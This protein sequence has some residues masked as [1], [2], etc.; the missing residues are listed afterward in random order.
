MITTCW[1]EKREQRWDVRA[2]YDLLSVSSVQEIAGSEGGDQCASQMTAC[3]E[4]FV[5]IDPRTPTRNTM[6]EPRS[7]RQPV[8]D[9]SPSNRQNTMVRQAAK[10]KGRKNLGPQTAPVPS[11]ATRKK[12]FQ[13]SIL[14][15]SGRDSESRTDRASQGKR[16]GRIAVLSWGRSKLQAMAKVLTKIVGLGKSA[17]SDE[18]PSQ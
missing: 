9:R 12:R 7:S 5:D 1:S 10:E 6:I 14:S 11:T 4:G 8:I 15:R 16:L 3:A 18:R 17:G 2:V 13:F